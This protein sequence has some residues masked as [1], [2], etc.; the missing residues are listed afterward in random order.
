MNNYPAIYKE[1]CN[2]IQ[3]WLDEGM[4]KHAVFERS[5]SLCYQ[6]FEWGQ[7]LYPADARYLLNYQSDLFRAAGLNG[8]MPFDQVNE[9]IPVY[10]N[11]QRLQ[12]VK[13]HC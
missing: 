10:Q 9:R 4:P 13:D 7:Q 5:A 12:W 11:T 3:K 1:F 6:L 8:L 2:D